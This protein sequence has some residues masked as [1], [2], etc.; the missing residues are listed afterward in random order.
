MTVMLLFACLATTVAQATEY[1]KDVILIGGTKAETDA[2]KESL[3]QQGWNLI[4]KDLNKGAGGDFIYLLYKSE[5]KTYNKGYITDLYIRTGNN[6][7]GSLI[8]NEHTYNL[9]LC[10][11]GESF[12][13]S[14]GDLNRGSLGD[15]I[16]LYYTRDFFTDN[17]TVTD[18]TFNGTKSGGLG[19][20][21]G[22]EG[23]DLNN[24]TRI[25]REEIYLHLTT[26]TA[27]RPDPDPSDGKYNLWLGKT[28][29]TVDNRDNILGQT[30]ANGN[31][32]AMYDGT[33]K[34]LTLNNPTIDG[35]VF[36]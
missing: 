22:S 36:Q 18:I 14:K 3:G 26:A 27:S 2:L 24:N 4:D 29:V 21:G 11:G 1:I 9:V 19:A 28:Q 34:T 5:E 12:V 33:T 25:H 32:R 35:Y 8:H 7:S 17:R 6:P 23:Y 31:P 15:Y 16:T 10:Q 13:N 30:D 20:N